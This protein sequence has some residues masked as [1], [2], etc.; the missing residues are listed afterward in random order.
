M[1]TARTAK[2][3]LMVAEMESSLSSMTTMQRLVVTSTDSQC[4]QDRILPSQPGVRVKYLCS[5]YY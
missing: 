3:P 5:N 1:Y 4:A 2:A